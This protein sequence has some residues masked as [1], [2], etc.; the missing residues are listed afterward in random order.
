MWL[1]ILCKVLNAAIVFAVNALFALAD[2]LF[3]LA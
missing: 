3:A 2:A 1:I